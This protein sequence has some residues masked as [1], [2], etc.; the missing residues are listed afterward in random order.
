M[1]K[2]FSIMMLAALLVGGATSCSLFLEKP[3]TTGTVDQNAIFS[4]QK[5]ANASLM[6]CYRNVL[7]HG[8]PG[9][10]GIGHCTL[11]AI[12]G[13]VGR[14][15]NWHG[16]YNIVQQ[17]LSVNGTDGS[18]AGAEHYGNNWSYIRQCWLTAENIDNVQ[19]MSDADKEI[20]KAECKALVAYRY[21]GMFYRYGGVPIVEKSF[22]SDDDL[23]APRA[24]LEE[25]VSF[26]SRLCDEAA[27]VLPAKWDAANTGR[28][29]KG[30]ALAIKARTLQFA[31]RPLFNSAKP[32]LDNGEHND[33]VCFGNYSEE[34]WRDAIKANE[35]VLTWAA[36]NGVALINT[37]G[38]VD[39][40]PNPNAFEDYATATSTPSN[41]ELILAYKFDD[42]GGWDALVNF[43]NCSR[44]QGNNRYD[45]D[46]SG[47][48]TNHLEKYWA[49]DGSEMSWPKIGDAVP[50]S[51]SDWINNVAKI[52]P[53]ALADIKFGGHDSANNPGDYYW[54][55]AGWN[56]G[57]YSADKGKGD[58]FPNA[59]DGDK[60]CGE[61][62]KFFYKAGNRTWFEPPLFRLA[63]TY[64][65]LAEAYNEVGDTENALKN[66]NRV[67]NRAGLPR[68]TETDKDK[69][70]EIIQRE[71][72][73]E[74]FQEGGH[75]YY[76]AKHWKR[77]DIAD[78]ICGGPM[79]MLQFNIK[80]SDDATWPY[81]AEWVETYWD[82]VAYESYWSDA[83]FL[84]PF[85]QT[86]INKGT[87][88]QNPGY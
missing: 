77:A 60:G 8:W 44:Y 40:L 61:R 59:I 71:C 26:I 55:N 27:E 63:E 14:G 7:R 62:T 15:Y 25:M 35:A 18:D 37:G 47:V 68:I 58:V 84:E 57:G 67:H 75:R 54:Q 52:E 34:R 9:G 21:M 74:F 81:A 49:A 32:Y 38:A 30:A 78:G 64:L 20:V 24:S 43:M 76:D 65:Y 45:T 82:A 86:E 36:A 73:V 48:L 17:G 85:P 28:M 5:N 72:A 79:R 12:S 41:Q 53:R 83:M 23:S 33:L 10:I 70:R 39:G 69:L 19:D 46:C 87:I 51:G 50:R 80:N 16:S 42:T 2:I 88:T 4:N 11:G 3:D 13:E 6:R 31:A 29:T 56:R 1:K 22:V 66:L